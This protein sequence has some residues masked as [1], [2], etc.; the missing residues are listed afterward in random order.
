MPELVEDTFKLD[1]TNWCVFERSDG[2]WRLTSSNKRPTLQSILGAYP[3][4]G[5]YTEQSHQVNVILR[6]SLHSWPTDNDFKVN[7][8]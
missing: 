6:P 5:S 7:L 1:P 4:L 8:E 2:I 3:I